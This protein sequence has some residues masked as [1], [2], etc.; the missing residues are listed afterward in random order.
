[1]A[2][3]PMITTML[4]LMLLLTW[5]GVNGQSTSDDDCCSHND[6]SPSLLQSMSGLAKYQLS[7]AENLDVLARDLSQVQTNLQR[8]RKLP[9]SPT[10]SSSEYS[11]D[12]LIINHPAIRKT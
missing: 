12:D 8:L 3:A 10:D 6:Q 1:M 11:I 2:V 4:L 5:N 7:A 9:T